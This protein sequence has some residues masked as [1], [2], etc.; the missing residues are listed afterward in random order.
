MGAYGCLLNQQVSNLKTGG[1][2]LPQVGQLWSHSSGLQGP[3]LWAERQPEPDRAGPELQCA[4]GCW[5]PTPLPETE[6][7]TLH[8]TATAV[9]VLGGQG[10]VEGTTCHHEAGGG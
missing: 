10:E 6:L 8:A 9:I 3:G 1:V 5:S 4:H 2:C 7:D